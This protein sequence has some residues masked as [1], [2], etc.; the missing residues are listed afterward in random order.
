[1]RLVALIPAFND[2]TELER[3]L[4]SLAPDPQPFD[5]V[6]VDD[7]SVPPLD[8]PAVAGSHQVITLRLDV[9]GGIARALNAGVAWILAQ[10]YDLV[11]RLDAGDLNMPQRSARQTAFLAQHP[12]VALVGGWTRHVDEQMRP[13]YVTRY[14]E[15]WEAIRK[16]LHY[17]T[18]FSH[19]AC[20]LRVSALRD[21][22]AYREDC[23]LGED[24]ELFWRLALRFPC[25]NLPEVVVTRVEAARSLTHANRLAMAW[26]RLRLQG[27]HFT[28]RRL[29]CW[30]G[31]GRSVAL[32]AV[33]VRLRLTMKRIAGTV[34]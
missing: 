6:V 23:P 4:A 10:G 33:P 11:A 13:L 19:G 18:A 20:M 9:N 16:R 5:V 34:G 21:A 3:T 32:L 12:E 8:V 1:M 31:I 22:G 17:R 14:P 25:A 28:W 15:G 29:D 2:R 26:S 7:G 27:Q 24:Y 30:L